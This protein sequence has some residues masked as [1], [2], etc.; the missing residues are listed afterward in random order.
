MAVM[1][2]PESPGGSGGRAQ[3]LPAGTV[4]YRSSTNHFYIR[5]QSAQCSIW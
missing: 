2:S 1:N 5:Q 3:T 4:R